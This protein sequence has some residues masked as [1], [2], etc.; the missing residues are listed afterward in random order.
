MLDRL[1]VDDF[2]P[3]IGDSFALGGDGGDTFDLE[4]TE[5]STMDPGHPAT[6]PEGRRTPFSLIF[7]GP[8]DPV[9]PQRIYRVEHAEVGPLEIFIVPVGRDESG[10]RYQAIFT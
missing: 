3:I 4:L 6:D 7:R 8:P 10:T 5:A 9:L 1:T 2:A